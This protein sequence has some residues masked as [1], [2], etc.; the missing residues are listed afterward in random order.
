MEI[1]LRAAHLSAQEY[2]LGLI[3]DNAAVALTILIDDEGNLQI[4]EGDAEATPNFPL[5]SAYD[6]AQLYL[7][8]AVQRGVDR[9]VRLA[10]DGE[11]RLTTAD[12]M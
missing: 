5:G 1:P 2:I 6:S 10:I 3:R 12:A 8:D 4:E 11:G 9:G 7:Y